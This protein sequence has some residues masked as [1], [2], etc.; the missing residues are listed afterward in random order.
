MAVIQQVLSFSIWTLLQKY[1]ESK[2]TAW[3]VAGETEKAVIKVKVIK[4]IKKM[5]IGHFEL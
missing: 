2:K 5:G 3:K 1:Y 4:V